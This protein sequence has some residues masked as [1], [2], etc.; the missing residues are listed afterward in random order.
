MLNGPGRPSPAFVAQFTHPKGP[1][2]VSWIVRHGLRFLLES[3][4]R[5]LTCGK[6]NDG[7]STAA[8]PMRAVV[9]AALRAV[10][11]ACWAF[12]L[13]SLTWAST[14]STR[15]FASASLKPILA[16]TILVM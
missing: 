6:T 7:A 15:P 9:A 3:D 14:M 10:S 12:T 5:L 16:E 8:A 13:A 11:A 4:D 1:A 2:N